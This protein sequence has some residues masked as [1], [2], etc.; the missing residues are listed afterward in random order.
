M[1]APTQHPHRSAPELVIVLLACAAISA[2]FASFLTP[3]WDL[4]NYFEPV[5]RLWLD[6]DTRLYD[7]GV[8]SG[9]PYP[10]WFLIYILPLA[11][12]SL[13]VGQLAIFIVSIW[14][15]YASMGMFTARGERTDLLPMIFM[16]GNLHFIHLLYLGQV[17]GLILIGIGWGWLAIHSRR[18]LLFAAALA[19]MTA[20]PVNIA[21]VILLYLWPV[22]RSWS[23]REQVI[24][25]WGPGVV[26]LAISALISGIDWPVRYLEHFGQEGKPGIMRLS[27]WELGLPG[28]L[29]AV[30]GAALVAAWLWAV[31]RTGVT[32]W[33]LS[34]AL[35]TNMLVSP[36]VMG[37]HYVLLTPAFIHIWKRSRTLAI[38]LWLL[39]FT[40]LVRAGGDAFNRAAIDALYPLA[41]LVALWWG[42][43]LRRLRAG[44]AG[45]QHPDAAPRRSTPVLRS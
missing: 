10:P 2:A 4:V 25:V 12:V 19:I 3:G 24:G 37:Y 32:R 8:P 29:V 41:M 23:L 15:I 39:M 13:R 43:E 28:P 44:D 22:L 36:Y 38:G 42:P 26:L 34:L 14:S 11:S 21:L 27:L 9:F 20:K 40:A 7:A 45:D 6:G 5:P 17:D 31:W 33:T 18:P 30:I 16:I 1:T 35:A